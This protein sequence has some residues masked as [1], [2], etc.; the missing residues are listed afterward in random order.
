M[1]RVA[2]NS[3]DAQ[4]DLGLLLLR[5]S[6]LILFATAGWEKVY[7]L[8]GAIE[9]GKPLATVGLAPLIAKMGFPF[10]VFCALFVVLNESVGAIL[11]SVGLFT[12]VV[13]FSAALSMTGAF[14][15][16]ATKGWEP[17]RAFMYIFIFAALAVS[18]AGRYSFDARFVKWKRLNSSADAGLLILRAGLLAFFV[19]LF[20]MPKVK[21]SESF[22]R[23][24]VALL[25]S[26]AG[27]LA[28]FVIIGYFTRIGAIL[29][30]VVWGWGAASAL[31]AGKPWDLL[32]YRDALLVL[33]FLVLAM[34]G[35]GRYSP[36][37][38]RRRSGRA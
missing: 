3:H 5:L 22:A 26:L 4:V 15:T 13:A 29:S 18:G 20:T 35:A 17:L 7:A 23:G 27:I 32:P 21:A 1:T 11:I 31:S 19:L 24:P 36:D 30:F 28:V 6:G 34:A 12:R 2:G 9:A 38:S 25:L 37:G 8:A 10:P 33:L 14:Y 16:A